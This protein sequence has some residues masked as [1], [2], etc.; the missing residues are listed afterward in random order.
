MPFSVRVHPAPFSPTPNRHAG[1][2]LKMKGGGPGGWAEVVGSNSGEEISGRPFP[3]G[4]FAISLGIP[5]GE[6]GGSHAKRQTPG[7]RQFNSYSSNMLWGVLFY[8]VLCVHGAAG[9][10]YTTLGVS[11]S[12]SEQEIKKSYRAL[13]KVCS[14]LA[15]NWS[16]CFMVSLSSRGGT[17]IDP[18]YVLANSDPTTNFPLPTPES[19]QLVQT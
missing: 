9:D 4:N 12:A 5:S 2:K 17:A 6:G 19:N 14:M 15:L 7:V 11:R 8:F 1:I 13:A 3:K 10:Y 18:L 16:C